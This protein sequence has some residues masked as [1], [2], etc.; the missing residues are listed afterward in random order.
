MDKRN[1]EEQLKQE[2]ERLSG[3]EVEV[4]LEKIN[5]LNGVEKDAVLLSREGDTISPAIY[6]DDFYQ[7]ALAGTGVCQIAA[8]ILGEYEKIRRNVADQNTDFFTCFEKAAPHIYCQLIH[9]KKNRKLLETIPHV[10]FLDLAVAYYYR[11]QET[12][13]RDATILIRESHRKVWGISGEELDHLA[14]ANTLRDL[15]ARLE[16]LLDYM[17]RILPVEE[18]LP[19]LEENS[20]DLA[21]SLYLLSNQNGCLGA[22]CMCY[23]DVLKKLAEHFQSDLFIIPSSIHECMILPDHGHYEENALS[24]IVKEVNANAVIPQ[25]ILSDHVYFYRRT[26]GTISR[27]A[28]R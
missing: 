2:L 3:G 22:V 4:K 23:P 12:S 26:R 7:Q 5:K 27:L 1:F 25:E 14:W 17:K 13:L 28:S 15:P 8:C 6:L 10:P 24:E 20:N 19:E 16:N 9:A 18:I 11:V 21:S